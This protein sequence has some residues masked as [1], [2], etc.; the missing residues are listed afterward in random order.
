MSRATFP[1]GIS[2]DIPPEKTPGE[3][4]IDASFASVDDYMAA[5]AK[6]KDSAAAGRREDCEH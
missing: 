3:V 6:I 4:L 5:L 1:P 2:T